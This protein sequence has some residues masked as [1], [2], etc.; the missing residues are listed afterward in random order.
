MSID[1]TC[2]ITAPLQQ[3]LSRPIASKASLTLLPSSISL[4]YSSQWTEIGVPHEIHLTG[5]IILKI[6]QKRFISLSIHQ[7]KKEKINNINLLKN[8]KL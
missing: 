4:L 8:K 2:D 3:N 5:I 1:S 7:T 6:N